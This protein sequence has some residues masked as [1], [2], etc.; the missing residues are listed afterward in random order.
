[1]TRKWTGGREGSEGRQE[2][3]VE[4][5]LGL[6][7]GVVLVAGLLVVMVPLILLRGWAIQTLWGWFIVPTFGLHPLRIVEAYGISILISLF[8]H[9][10]GS[11]EKE[12]EK[13]WMPVVGG[14]FGTLIA[15][16][17]GWVVR[18]WM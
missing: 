2:T 4:I 11:R 3:D 10:G 9:S 1:M 7:V 12:G 5:L 17:V 13:W 16:G 6:G 15:V 14:V 8:T 18:R